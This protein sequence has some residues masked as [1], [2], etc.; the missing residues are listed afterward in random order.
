MVVAA[1]REERGLIAHALHE[2]E[3]EH[4]A[5]EVER[6]VDVGDLEMDVAD[7]HPGIDRRWGWLCHEAVVK[8]AARGG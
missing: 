8:H 1:C 3:A 7:V 5:V 2:V 4:A 6:A